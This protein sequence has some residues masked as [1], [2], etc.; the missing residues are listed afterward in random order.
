LASCSAV[1][2]RTRAATGGLYGVLPAT[3]AISFRS[4]IS[5]GQLSGSWIIWQS[6][7]YRKCHSR[8]AVSTG[9]EGVHTPR[10]LPA[11]VDK[12]SGSERE[13]CRNTG[14]SPPTICAARCAPVAG[15]QLLI[16]DD[17]SPGVRLASRISR[18]S[19]PISPVW[20]RWCPVDDRIYPFR[21]GGSPTIREPTC[22]GRGEHGVAFADS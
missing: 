9:R 18:I 16:S 10:S 11:V 5:A 1:V 4:P 19:M 8:E 7:A 13:E 20:H 3:A 17:P 21:L 12:G 2:E 22:G 14:M 6:G 15:A